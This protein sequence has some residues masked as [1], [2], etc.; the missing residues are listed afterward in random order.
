V[1]TLL[2]K[3]INSGVSLRLIDVGGQKTERKK[4]IHFFEGVSTIIF[5]AALS[6]YDQAMQED[7]DKVMLLNSLEPL[8]FILNYMNYW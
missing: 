5:C 2:F 3:R 1:A 7:P 8:W 6:D 4:W